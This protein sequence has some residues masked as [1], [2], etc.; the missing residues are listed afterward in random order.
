MFDRE[1]AE[2]QAQRHRQIAKQR[3]AT[4]KTRDELDKQEKNGS[5]YRRKV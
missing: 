4:S 1:I 2:E 3:A 5:I